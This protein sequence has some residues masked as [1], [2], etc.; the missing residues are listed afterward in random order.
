MSGICE[1]CRGVYVLVGGMIISS[2]CD[3]SSVLG[4][5]KMCRKENNEFFRF[6]IFSTKPMLPPPSIGCEHTHRHIKVV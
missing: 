4:G 5:G 2:M 3:L 6:F 1:V